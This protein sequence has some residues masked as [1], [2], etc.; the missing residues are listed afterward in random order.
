MS[1]KAK[2]TLTDEQ[3]AIREANRQKAAPYKERRMALGLSQKQL[4]E[5]AGVG[6]ATIVSMETGRCPPTWETCQK[7]RRVLGMPEEQFY[8]IRE[9]VPLT[10]E[11]LAIR[12][13]NRQKAVP[14]K[15]RRIALELSQKQLAEKAGVARVT[16]N[17]ME[18]GK[19]WPRWDTCQKIRRALGMPEERFYSV[20][21]KVPLTEEQIAIREANRQKAAPYKERRMAL[22]LSR[23][24]LAEKAGIELHTICT[25]EAGKVWPRWETRQKIRRALGMPEERAYSV[26]ERNAIF[27]ELNI[28]DSV[29]WAI[30]KNFSILKA[31]GAISYLDDLRQDLTLCAIRSIDR[32]QED[33]E[34]SLKTFVVTNLMF[35][36]KDWIAKFN[37]RGMSGK[38]KYP[39]PKIRVFS[40]DALMESAIG[41]FKEKAL[42]EL[43]LQ[44]GTSQNLSVAL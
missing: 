32:F 34:A 31:M 40:L 2:V 33:G 25:M 11:Q 37:M 39:L 10:G 8:S 12:E 5:K 24:Q 26:E 16:I 36:V 19:V 42:L 17:E 27:F 4:A 41:K 15:E 18:T 9:K 7:V 1:A 29:K 23:K 6:V 21:T 28:E 14:Y 44:Q 43:Q 13:A 35:F 20:R 30:R 38:I 22:E 3:L